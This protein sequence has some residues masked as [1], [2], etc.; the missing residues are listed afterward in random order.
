MMKI[1]LDDNRI[2]YLSENDERL[3]TVIH[4][5]GSIEVKKHLNGYKFLVCEIV[6]QMLSNKIADNM[7]S[8]LNDLC[9]EDIT[10]EKISTI[11]FEQLKSIGISTVKVQYINALTDVIKMNRNFWRDFRV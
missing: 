2:I 8:R 4:S 7:I 11:P 9:E 10:P 6:G 1:Q 3:K 5:I